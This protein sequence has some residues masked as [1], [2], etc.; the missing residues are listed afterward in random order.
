MEKQNDLINLVMDVFDEEVEKNNVN[1]KTGDFVELLKVKL[2]EAWEAEDFQEE[3]ENFKNIYRENLQTTDNIDLD[4]EDKL[5][6]LSVIRDAFN[7]SFDL[8]KDFELTKDY[9]TSQKGLTIDFAGAFFLDFP[10]NNL[11]FSYVPKYSLWISPS[12]TLDG[13]KLGFLTFLGVLR[14]QGHNIKFYE[15]L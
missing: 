12:Y 8:E 11:E 5:K 14:Y 15:I 7:Q 13:G 9:V 2:D 3:I 10:R 6:V 4:S 1:I